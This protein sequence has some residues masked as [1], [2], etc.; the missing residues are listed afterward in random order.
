MRREVDTFGD[1][2]FVLIS[3][4]QI[5]VLQLHRFLDLTQSSRRCR[6]PRQGK[7]TATS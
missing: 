5:L 7:R 3:K 6:Q 4:T 2:T 1:E